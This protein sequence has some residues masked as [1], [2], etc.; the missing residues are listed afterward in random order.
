MSACR[1][2]RQAKRGMQPRAM[3]EIDYS[4]TGDQP[5]YAGGEGK[6]G[7]AVNAGL[8]ED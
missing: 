2:F 1:A 4:P 5:S 8:T 3:V 7:A 6:L